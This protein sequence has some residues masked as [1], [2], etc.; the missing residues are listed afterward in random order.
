[1]RSFS[2]ALCMTL[3]SSTG[4]SGT[5]ALLLN[6]NILML[7]KLRPLARDLLYSMAEVAHPYTVINHGGESFKVP[8]RWRKWFCEDYEQ[9][10]FDFIRAHCRSGT[11][12]IDIGAHFGIFTISA[13]R[14]VGA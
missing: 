6:L 12:L 4:R 7:P 3:S 11:T 14:K 5:S 2:I 13:L 9:P 10:T 1:M 8:L